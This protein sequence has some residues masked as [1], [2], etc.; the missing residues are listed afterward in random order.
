MAYTLDEIR[1]YAAITRAAK[2]LDSSETIAA[3]ESLSGIKWTGYSKGQLL[4]KYALDPNCMPVG[5]LDA[6]IKK[7]RT[8]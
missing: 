6:L 5:V 2:G 3:I 7:E 1:R 8:S 4:A